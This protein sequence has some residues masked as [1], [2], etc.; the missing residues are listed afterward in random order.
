MVDEVQEF[1]DKFDELEFEAS[2]FVYCGILYRKIMKKRKKT[3]K[4]D[5]FFVV[6]ATCLF[7]S[8]KFILDD[9]VVMLKDYAEFIGMEPEILEYVEITLL[10][11]VLHFKLPFSEKEFLSEIKSINSMAS[12][13][14]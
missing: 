13:L 9:T 8:L 3:A 14:A 6:F 10:V 12:N 1:L 11:N 7:I 5:S 4:N 2:A